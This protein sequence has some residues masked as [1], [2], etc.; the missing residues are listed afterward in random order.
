MK[1]HKKI[2]LTLLFLFFIIGIYNCVSASGENITYKAGYKSPT[3]YKLTITGLEY[4]E[5]YNYYA[6]ICQ[7][8]DI[9]GSDFYATGTK[10]FS[11]EYNLTTNTWEGDTVTA[12]DGLSKMYGAFEKAGQYYAYIARASANGVSSGSDYEIIDGP[13]AI[14]TPD[15]PPLGERISIK[16]YSLKST[17]YYIKVNAQN[18]MIY[19]GVQRTIRFY[20]GE[21][22][23]TELLSDL[24]E[25]KEGSYDRLLQY[26]KNQV[27]NLKQD[28]FQDTKTGFLD[29]NIVANYPIQDG[30]YY[31]LYSILDNEN[32][33]YN[34]VEDIEIYNGDSSTKLTDFKYIPS[35]E[36]TDISNNKIT[37]NT[38]A[39]IRL[40]AAGMPTIIISAIIVI[41]IFVTVLYIKNKTYRDIK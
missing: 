37:D 15:L 4:E 22:T 21:V 29:Y 41:G 23:D 34:D 40:P 28:S 18:T 27:P 3:T 38:T 25:N 9:T 11:I 1:G 33:I 16:T 2:F 19:S 12:H 26:A 36:N 20:V 30:K 14:E 31:F 32:G 10:A 39:H 5:G 8:T 6:M 24:S 17:Y 35:Q 13:T 7:E